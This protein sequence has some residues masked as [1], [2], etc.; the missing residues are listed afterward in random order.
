LTIAGYDGSNYIGSGELF[1]WKTGAQCYLEPLPQ[2]IQIKN[3]K[4]MFGIFN[5]AFIGGSQGNDR[6]IYL[7]DWSAKE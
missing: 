1:N 5:L 4:K 7:Y 2:V 3:I 6:N